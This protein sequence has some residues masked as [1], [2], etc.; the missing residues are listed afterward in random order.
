M[1]DYA[2]ALEAAQARLGVAL[3]DPSLHAL[4]QLDGEMIAVPERRLEA[5]PLGYWTIV[6]FDASDTGSVVIARLV[7]G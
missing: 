4:D 7:E 6:P 3:F 5:P 1:F 2:S